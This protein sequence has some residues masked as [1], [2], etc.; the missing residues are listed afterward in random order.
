MVISI[1]DNPS[2]FCLCFWSAYDYLPKVLQEEQKFPF[3]ELEL[4]IAFFPQ[5]H[6]K[7]PTERAHSQKPKLKYYSHQRLRGLEQ[8]D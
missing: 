4:Y 5:G 1:F 6:V 3:G 7:L 2:I 8:V